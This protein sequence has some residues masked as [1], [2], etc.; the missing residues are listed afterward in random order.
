MPKVE[1]YIAYMTELAKKAG[2]TDEQAKPLLEALKNDTIREG[3]VPRP[4]YSSDLDRTRAEATTS[5]KAFYDN[6]F[7]TEGKPAHDKALAA[8][9]ELS[10]YKS[11]YG[12]LDGDGN[13][14]AGAKTNGNYLTQEQ[15]QQELA[16]SL[17]SV[18]AATVA[19]Q[20]KSMRIAAQH[21][22]DFQEVLDPDDL[23]KFAT[24][25]NLSDID[26]AYREYVS[27]RIQ[28]RQAAEWE[29][30]VKKAKEEGALEERSRMKT[31]TPGGREYTNPFLK[32]RDVKADDPEAGRAAFISG[33]DADAN[34]K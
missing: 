24:E 10:K 21:L 19:M 5:A 3:F 31:R 30:K 28:K 8:I 20:K 9:S 27:P 4:N 32:P 16:K 7:A 18:N 15:F 2:F 11:L 14:N 1:D 29:E 17:S 26:L 33:W 12:D 23:E 13:A 6:W 34:K 22:K 25:H